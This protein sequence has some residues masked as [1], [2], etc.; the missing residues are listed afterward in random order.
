MGGSR[1]LS[2]Q[3]EV[4]VEI[5][6]GAV[7]ETY[8]HLHVLLVG[9]GQSDA[10]GCTFDVVSGMNDSFGA[11][12]HFFQIAVGP[13]E[14]CLFALLYFPRK[15][16]KHQLEPVPV[17]KEDSQVE[18]TALLEMLGGLDKVTSVHQTGLDTWGVEYGVDTFP[19]QVHA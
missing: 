12:G 7:T 5:V 1:H 9:L 2:N 17:E 15:G 4:A 11:L 19:A 13:K 14:D 6:A 18:D 3:A 8:V 10:E 16:Q